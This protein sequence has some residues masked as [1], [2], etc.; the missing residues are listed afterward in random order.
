MAGSLLNNV[1]M[2]SYLSYHKLMVVFS[3]IN[4]GFC[5]PRLVL[6]LNLHTQSGRCIFKECTLLFEQ[7]LLR[8]IKLE[9]HEKAGKERN[10]ALTT[11][12]MTKAL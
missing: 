9:S 2:N 4:S 11:W 10:Q 5:P 1:K 12:R 8:G 6:H 3:A 7:Y